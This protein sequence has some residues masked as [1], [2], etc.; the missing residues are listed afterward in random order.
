MAKDS[1]YLLVFAKVCSL[2]GGGVLG[3]AGLM[4]LLHFTQVASIVIFSYRGGMKTRAT[5]VKHQEVSYFQQQR[6]FVSFVPE[7]GRNNAI[8]YRF[9]N[10]NIRL[11]CPSRARFLT[12]PYFDSFVPSCH[13][14]E[15]GRMPVY[16]RD[17]YVAG[18]VQ[19]GD[20][21]LQRL[22]AEM[23]NSMK[24]TLVYVEYVEKITNRQSKS[25]FWHQ[26]RTGRTT[27]SNAHFVLCT[28]FEKPAQSILKGICKGLMIN[29]MHSS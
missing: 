27:A 14:P 13:P 28:S 18:N 12:W 7:E 8:R 2:G 24:A 17:F 26:V 1:S 21:E 29:N 4:I 11:S 25:I 16:L 3:L 9:C 6:I 5:Q 19:N 20:I 22:G 10:E 23:M 15:R